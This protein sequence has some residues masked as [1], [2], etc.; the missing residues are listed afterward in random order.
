MK[1]SGTTRLGARIA[2]AI[3]LLSFATIGSARK[4]PHY[5][6]VLPDG[7][8]GWIQV[9]FQA[10]DAQVPVFSKDR[11]LLRVDETGVLKT[12]MI[13][14]YFTGSHDEFLYRRIGEHG[15]EALVRV[16]STYFCN[17]DSG[18]DSCFDS[19]SGRS[20][21][22]TV[23]RATVGRTSSSADG[24]SWFLFVGP[25]SLR[26]TLSRPV[27]FYPNTKKQ[28]DVPEDDPT[29]GRIKDE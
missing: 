20:D 28:I 29:P 25:P 15:T 6:F 4:L 11:I 1:C 21:A 13:H 2:A 18:I 5:T 10:H 17:G 27:H 8:T 24:N 9:I 7:Y 16:P 26:E 22:F 23:S 12:S 14:T 19:R 3:L